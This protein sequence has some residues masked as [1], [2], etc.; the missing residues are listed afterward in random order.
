MTLSIIQE[1][2]QVTIPAQIRNK[3][4][5]K[6]GDLVAFLETDNG[7]VI[8]AQQTIAVDAM[9]KIG[10]ALKENGV[11]I[12]DLIENGRQIRENLVKRDYPNLLN[13]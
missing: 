2:G 1:K 12:E 10:N 13:D 9:N 11:K 3:L 5:L 7:V 4:G 8:S 6:K